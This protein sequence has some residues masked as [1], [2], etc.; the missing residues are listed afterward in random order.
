MATIV[1]I[2]AR[3]MLTIGESAQT[4]IRHIMLAVA[5]VANMAADKSSKGREQRMSIA[6]QFRTAFALFSHVGTALLESPKVNA[7]CSDFLVGKI[8]ELSATDGSIICRMQVLVERGG[9]HLQK[10][11]FVKHWDAPVVSQF[12]I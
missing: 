7:L 5:K 8:F 9:L 12:E 4:D 3:E 2:P 11:D 1:E 10:V 6:R